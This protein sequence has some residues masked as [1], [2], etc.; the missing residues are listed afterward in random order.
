[1]SQHQLRI[2]VLETDLN[3]SVT[4]ATHLRSAQLELQASFVECESKAETSIAEYGYKVDELGHMRSIVDKLVHNLNVIL[5]LVDPEASA[6]SQMGEHDPLKLAKYV[7]DHV[8]VKISELQKRL[9]MLSN[10]LSEKEQQFLSSQTTVASSESVNNKLRDQLTFLLDDFREVLR[11][12]RMQ[13]DDKIRGT[14]SYTQ[15]KALPPLPNL[16]ELNYHLTEENETDAP[17]WMIEQSK[18]FFDFLLQDLGECRAENNDVRTVVADSDV[19]NVAV[20]NKPKE[21]DTHRTQKCSDEASEIIKLQSLLHSSQKLVKEFRDNAVVLENRV[22]DR[23]VNLRSCCDSY[24]FE[25][26][27]G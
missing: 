14:G 25:N 7:Q 15:A 20:D 16:A 13:V 10:E 5:G 22:R 8:N 26:L 23:E 19:K 11:G 17:R 3:S 1:V 9:K 2:R 27:S 4:H 6:P 21:T 12:V 24:T 18:S